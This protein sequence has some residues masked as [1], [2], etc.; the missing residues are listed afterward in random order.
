M[1]QIMVDTQKKKKKKTQRGNTGEQILL[2]EPRKQWIAGSHIYKMIFFFRINSIKMV[3][4]S[5]ISLKSV[6]I[7]FYFSK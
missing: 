3:W 5:K 1:V 7:S 4:S 6:K 2:N